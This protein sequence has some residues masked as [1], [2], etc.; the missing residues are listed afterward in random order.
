MVT[1]SHL[2]LVEPQAALP[3]APAQL[4]AG[5]GTQRDAIQR[6]LDFVEPLYATRTL[7]TGEPV[8]EHVLAVA[9]T[10]SELKLDGDALTAALVYP[11]YGLSANAAVS[12]RE[13]FGG[14]VAELAEG[15]VKMAQIGAL[16]SRGAGSIG[17]QQQAA[18]LESLRNM[19][20]AMVQDVRVVLIKLAAHLQDLRSLVKAPETVSRTSAAAV[21][22]DIFAP[23][24]NRLGVW[25]LKWELEDLA[26]RILEP[27]IYRE[28]AHLLDE[29]RV[30]REQYIET[31]IAILSRELARA[32]IEAE[33][34]GRPKHLYSI[35]KKMRRK[36][37]GFEAL[38]DVRAVRVLVEDVKDCYS[39]LGIVHHLWSPLPKEFDD[40]IAKPKSNQYR[41]LHTAVIGPGGK[42]VEIQIRTH[43]MHQ[44]SE[45]GVAAH[46]RYKEGAAHD[47]SYQQK[48][49]WLR[50]I[51]E[52]KDEVSDASELAE[53]FKT[54]LFSDTLYVLTPQGRVIDLPAGATPIDFAYHVHTELGHRCRGAKV[55]GAI[56][57]LNTPLKNGQQ[58]E[59]LTTKQGGPS[60]D[61]LNPTLGF[62]KSHGA[63]AKVRQWFNRQNFEADLAHGR[64][65]LEKELQRHGATALNLE[66][67]A[68]D[69]GYAKLN[70]LLVDIARGE[71][72]P[73]Q[74]HDAL[75][76][77]LPPEQQL[78]ALQPSARKPRG[79]GQSSVLI[80]G[81]DKLLTLTAKCCKP[82]PP[83]PIVGFV[84]RGRGVSVH[85][86]DCSNVKRLNVERCV[87]AEWGEAS[88]ATFPVDVTVEALDRTGLLRD[89]SEV[90]TRERINVTATATQTTA[91]VARM[92]FT[93]EIEN[94][95]QLERVLGFIRD[96]R[97]VISARRR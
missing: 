34:T 13:K 51:L 23:L 29:K 91:H 52:W 43:E 78:D 45:L 81:V 73:K 10:L 21:T 79:G 64:A 60:R 85:R 55:D 31:V 32:G 58:V 25:H 87:P 96:L 36:N 69:L 89:I 80:V 46:W 38:H 63:R 76:P 48:L 16:T 94:I 88:G 39:V 20:L 4:L 28:I 11:A 2:K 97:G 49:A 68:A 44:H 33:V 82:A 86:A 9:Q 54:E 35:Y 84:T 5:L 70:D 26:F 77:E 92:R 65:L 93:L 15:V 12:V 95:D 17:L 62:L 3:G 22:R 56:V 50:Q 8:L 14:A 75:K 41:S 18:Q 40:Y 27:P 47:R 30:D 42:S 53:Q 19:L 6:V 67:L 7:A 90:L 57:P 59:I 74:L 72:G 83:D 1:R 71:V 61:W 37:I 66:R 24:A